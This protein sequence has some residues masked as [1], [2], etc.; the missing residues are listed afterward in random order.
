MSVLIRE[1][2]V[3]CVCVCVHRERSCEGMASRAVG[4][5]RCRADRCRRPRGGRW[6]R[7]RC[8]GGVELMASDGR[9]SRRLRGQCW[10]VEGRSPRVLGPLVSRRAVG[11]VG[12][13]GSRTAWLGLRGSGRWVLSTCRS[14]VEDA[15]S[16]P[17]GVPMGSRCEK[18]IFA[19]HEEVGKFVQQHSGR[20]AD[21]DPRK[22]L[23]GTGRNS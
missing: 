14:G 16:S 2:R 13:V 17:A 8:V 19:F 9:G 15:M 22:A 1:E 7:G 20:S 12:A 10:G 18:G 6:L 23:P 4:M 3:W 5:A 11:A 21:G